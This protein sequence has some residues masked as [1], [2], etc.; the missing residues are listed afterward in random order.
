MFLYSDWPEHDWF[1]PGDVPDAWIEAVRHARALAGDTRSATSGSDI[2]RG[3]SSPNRL[4]GQDGDDALRGGGGAD[5]LMGNSGDDRVSG[6]G[7]ND[8][9]RGGAGGDRLWGGS[10]ADRLSG[11]RGDDTRTGGAGPD[12]FVLSPGRDLVM[13]FDPSTDALA[14]QGARFEEAGADL[15]ASGK[16][17]AL[18]LVGLA[19]TPLA[20][21]DLL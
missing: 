2:L 8:D 7:G 18:V 20:D 19:G 3:D 5:R 21:L 12:V 9:L 10:G 4:L 17:G 6:S 13:D 16:S 1:T 14:A 15:V 11:G